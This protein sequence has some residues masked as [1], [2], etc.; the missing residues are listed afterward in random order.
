MTFLTIMHVPSRHAYPGVGGG[1]GG[2][3]DKAM[4]SALVSI[5]YWLEWPVSPTVVYLVVMFAFLRHSLV[6]VIIIRHRTK[7]YTG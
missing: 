1:G 7:I 6:V 4:Q 2:C 3:G 5:S